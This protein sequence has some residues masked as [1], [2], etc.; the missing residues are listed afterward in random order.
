MRRRS[1]RLVADPEPEPEPESEPEPEP[2][3]RRAR[4]YAQPSQRR[5]WLSAAGAASSGGVDGGAHRRIG[6]GGGDARVGGAVHEGV[7]LAFGAGN[8]GRLGLRFREIAIEEVEPNG[9]A[10]QH[11]SSLALRPGMVLRSI[12]GL[13][14]DQL[15]YNAIATIARGDARGMSLTFAHPPDERAND[16]LVTLDFGGTSGGQLGI[17]FRRVAVERIDPAGMAAFRA[18]AA[19]QPGMVLDTINQVPADRLAY[20]AILQ[21]ATDGEISGLTMSFVPNDP[22]AEPA[23]QPPPPPPDD[24]DDDDDPLGLMDDDDDDETSSMVSSIDEDDWPPSDGDAE[25][26]SHVDRGGLSDEDRA[27]LG[28]FTSNLMYTTRHSGA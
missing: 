28:K 11:V 16:E 27:A 9:A 21:L 4:T 2:D 10:D 6:R 24:G 13:R 19:L 25:M 5:S 12:N 26:Y 15:A 8:C 23:Q 18:G 1:A 14:A 7:S 3:R 20:N 17:R 22:S